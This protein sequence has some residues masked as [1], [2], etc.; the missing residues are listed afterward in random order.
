VTVAHLEVAG[1]VWLDGRVNGSDP[2]RHSGLSTP[3]RSQAGDAQNANG[4]PAPAHEIRAPIRQD[5]AREVTVLPSRTVIDA[6]HRL[7][8]DIRLMIGNP[9]AKRPSHATPDWMFCVRSL[10]HPNDPANAR[11]CRK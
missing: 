10:A 6:A 1:V 3:R 5:P 7:T 4:R 8:R 2:S 11:I 9:V